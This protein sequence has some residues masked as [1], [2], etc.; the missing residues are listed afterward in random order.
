MYINHK[1]IQVTESGNILSDQSCLVTAL[2]LIGS[3]LADGAL[4][5]AQVQYTLICV[6][7]SRQV[8]DF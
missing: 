1:S 7:L 2:K 5:A 8:I 3:K 4:T 6:C